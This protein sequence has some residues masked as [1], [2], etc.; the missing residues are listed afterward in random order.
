MDGIWTYDMIRHYQTLMYMLNLH[1]LMLIILKPVKL[2][3]LAAY[4][5]CVLRYISFVDHGNREK[6][7]LLHEIY[8][9]CELSL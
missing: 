3:S 1:I 9:Q 5:A 6:Y 2:P 4:L 8:L 7:A